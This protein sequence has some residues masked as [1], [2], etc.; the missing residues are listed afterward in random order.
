MTFDRVKRICWNVWFRIKGIQHGKN[1]SYNPPFYFDTNIGGKLSFGDNLS[2]NRNVT[3]SPSGY[4]E[5]II[6]NDV[7]I[8]MNTVLRATNHDPADHRKHIPGRIIIGNDVWIGANCVIL[9]DVTIGDHSVIGAG[10][11]VTKDI[12]ANVIA[13]GNPCRPIKNIE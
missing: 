8:G 10:S 3:I 11:I 6:G 5:I 13:V 2:L 4:G 9:P 12:P 7:A 1:F